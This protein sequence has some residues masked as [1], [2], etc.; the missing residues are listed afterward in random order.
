MEHNHVPL[1]LSPILVQTALRM[2]W[3]KLFL[4]KFLY[5]SPKGGHSLSLLSWELSVMVKQ[6]VLLVLAAEWQCEKSTSNWLYM[7]LLLPGILDLTP[8]RCVQEAGCLLLLLIL[9]YY[10]QLLCVATAKC[11]FVIRSKTYKLKLIYL[12][13]EYPIDMVLLL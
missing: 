12:H 4:S 3:R 9:R 2:N 10:T 11:K 1:C 6:L 5:N 8:S 13:L 7:L